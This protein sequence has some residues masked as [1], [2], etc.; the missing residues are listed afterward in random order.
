MQKV[1]VIGGG[2]SGII[3]ALKASQKNEVIIVDENKALA[4]KILVTGNGRSNFWNA[5]IDETKYYTSNRDFLKNILKRKEDVYTYLTCNLGITPQNK[6]GYIYPYSNTAAS[7]QKTFIDEVAKR[8]IKVINNLIVEDIEVGDDITVIFNDASKISADRVIIAT[9]SLAGNAS[10]TANNLFAILKKWG[11]EVTKLKPALVPL[12]A[13]GNFL[14]DWENTRSNAKISVYK[15][16]KVI[17]EETGEIQLTN[18][19]ISGI[20][21]FNVSSLVQDL[22][23]DNDPVTIYLDFLPDISDIESFLDEKNKNMYSATLEEILETI[24]NYKLNNVFYKLSGLKKDELYCN[25]ENKSSLF[26]LIKHFPLKITGTLDFDHAQVCHGGVNLE[27]INTDFHLKK[28]PRISL[29]G[30]ILDVDG[31]CGG[32]NLAF[33]FISGYIAGESLND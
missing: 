2:A 28:E 25:I 26:N 15:D 21:T 20:V 3:A 29:V 19:G 32:Y 10:N 31:I 17:C 1:I 18:Y 27:E 7:I 6:N 12:K 5:E 11:I 9:G 23:E 16:N 24:F 14:K 4:K 33:A 22:L 8:N 13:E 30:E